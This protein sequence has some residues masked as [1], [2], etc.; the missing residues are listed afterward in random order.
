MPNVANK[1]K[2]ALAKIR[3]RNWTLAS[4]A[5]FDTNTAKQDLFRP[6]EDMNKKDDE[7]KSLLHLAANDGRESVVRMLLDGGADISLQN[8]DQ[9]TPLHYAASYNH[10]AVVGLLLDRNA[11]KKSRSKDGCTPLAFAV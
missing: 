6:G 2:D 11:N 1:R 3:D 8:K 5:K 10:E 7:G 4:V 9:W